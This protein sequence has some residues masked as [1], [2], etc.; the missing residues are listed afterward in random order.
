MTSRHP[1]SARRRG[2]FTLVELMVSL[3]V[4][5]IV[6]LLAREILAS[7]TDGADRTMTA[8]RETDRRFNRRDW[9]L[10]AFGS[11]EFSSTPQRG[12]AGL[13][14]SPGARIQFTT[15]AR[16]DS[17]PEYRLVTISLSPQG[18][19]RARL[20]PETG[21]RGQ[22][23]TL[24]LADSVTTFSADHLIEYGSNSKWVSEWVSPVSGPVAARL[25]ISRQSGTDTLL[26]RIGTR[27]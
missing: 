8:S 17:V 5:G 9:L 22:S 2:G 11:A 19:L 12:F 20:D 24:D 10:R 27:G 25:R 3:A 26:L 16:V 15:L 7:V 14:G 13:R 18:Q 4:S 1:R 6:I 23:A 21:D